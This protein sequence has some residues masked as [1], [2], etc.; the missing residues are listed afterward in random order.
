MANHFSRFEIEIE[1]STQ[2]L[3]GQLYF[4]DPMP[5]AVRFN[6]MCVYVFACDLILMMMMMMMMMMIAYGDPL[7]GVG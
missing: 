7:H 5:T 1:S 2:E 6:A 4:R 3:E